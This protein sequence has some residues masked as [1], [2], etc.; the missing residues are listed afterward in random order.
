MYDLVAL[1]GVGATNEDASA[2]TG[3]SLPTLTPEPAA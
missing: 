2:C 3:G 1:A